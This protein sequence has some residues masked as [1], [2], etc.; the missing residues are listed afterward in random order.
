MR[1]AVD[2]GSVVSLPASSGISELAGRLRAVVARR[3]SLA[4]GLWGDPG[5]GKSFTAGGALRET[6]CTSFTLLAAMPLE[7]L[8]RALPRPPRLVFWAV[9]A[10]ERLE[11]GEPGEASLDLALAALL[12]ELAPVALL[13]EDAHE[14]S[15][16]RRALLSRLARAVAHARGVALL[17]TGRTPPPEGFEAVHLEPPPSETVRAMLEAEIGAALPPEAADW[18]ERRTRGNPLFALEHL[19]YLARTGYLWNDAHRW[20]WR[21]PPENLMP[22]TVEALIER[23]LEDPTITEVARGALEARAILP[24][25]AP[26]GLWAEVARLSRDALEGAMRELEA[27]NL[28]RGG[29]FSHPLFMEVAARGLPPARRRELSRRAMNA[30]E[31]DPED[32]AAFV[33]GAGL[34]AEA[35]LERLHRAART[36]EVAGHPARAARYLARAAAFAEGEA[37]VHLALEA[38]RALRETDLNEAQRLTELAATERPHDPDVIRL[39]A[40]LLARQGLGLEAERLLE[41]LPESVTT[42]HLGERLRLRALAGDNAGAFELYRDHPELL[43]KND[44]EIAHHVAWALFFLRHHEEA[45]AVAARSLAVPG[46][47]EIQRADLLSVLAMIQNVQG[48]SERAEALFG[49]ALTAYQQTDQATRITETLFNRARALRDLGRFPEMM[50]DL[51][52]AG[53]LE[54][55]RGDGHAYAITQIS[56]AEGWLEFGEYARAEEVLLESRAVLERADLSGY[57]VA[58]EVGLCSLYRAWEPPHGDALALKHAHAAVRTARQLGDPGS[59]GLALIG[60]AVAESWQGQPPRALELADEAL[61]RFNPQGRPKAIAWARNARAGAL[62]RLGRGDEALQDERTAHALAKGANLA[63]ETERYGLEIDR[64]TSD[65]ERALERLA[66]FESRGLH[67]G[68]NLVRRYFPQLAAPDASRV[69]RETTAGLPHLEVLGPMR[70]GSDG[71]TAPLRGRKRRELLACLLEARLAGR[72]EISQFVLIERLYPDSGPEE[73]ATALKQLVFQTRASLGQ[74]VIATTGGGYALGA[75]QSDA[76]R[77]LETGDSGLWR[78]AYLEGV[79]L[80]DPDEAVRD[81]LYRA[82]FERARSLLPTEAREAARLG[83]LLCEAD[84]YDLEALRVTL[85]ALRQGGNHR[86][87]GRLYEAARARLLEVGEHL[88]EDWRAFLESRAA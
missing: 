77:F 6:G 71:R 74:G 64:L 60:A 3:S 40:E 82:L 88:P 57:L 50:A 12:V 63:L 52:E 56:M 72:A 58:C 16:E 59:L 18:I 76:E 29:E 9:R 15:P 26:L 5:V 85:R 7:A 81:A 87:L 48:R 44:P 17:L 62:E 61:E 8:A 49:E 70:F 68:A 31:H 24:H 83:R 42:A 2:S 36:A 22:G 25:G 33:E 75:I 13:F 78:G 45:Q 23:L 66:W 41:R 20:R 53:R 67:H 65:A 19:R 37:R 38:A 27:L 43:E 14:A 32:A 21:D 46:L 30:L 28:M 51:E 80:S 4:V 54:A 84:P 10:L 55:R 11:R 86:G 69:S 73:G 34:G 1:T 39:R 35:S 79:P 47:D